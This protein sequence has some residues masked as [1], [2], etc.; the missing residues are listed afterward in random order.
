MLLNLDSCRV[1]VADKKAATPALVLTPDDAT[2][3]KQLTSQNQIGKIEPGKTIHYYSNGSFNLI[4]LMFFVLDQIVPA[5]CFLATYSIATDSI[6]KLRRNVDAGTIRSIRFLIDNRVRSISPKPFDYLTRAF[7]ENYRCCA[8]HAKVLL[9][10]NEQFKISI[11]GSQN[12]THNPKLER[13]I[14]HTQPEILEYDRECLQ[15]EFLRGST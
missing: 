14:I 4:Q 13:G 15:D 10:W 5:D 9:L 1:G 8:L 11:I 6:E 3:L 7:P 12:A 2:T